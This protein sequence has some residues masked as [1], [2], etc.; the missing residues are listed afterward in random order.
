M[1]DTIGD[2]GRYEVSSI[3]AE[4]HLNEKL[5]ILVEW[6]SEYL[7]INYLLSYAR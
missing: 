1:S 5:S 6:Y 7:C 3:V 2:F 4:I